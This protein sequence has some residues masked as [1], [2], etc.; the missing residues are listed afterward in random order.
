M[1]NKE[2]SRR[3]FLKAVASAAAASVA[4]SVAG[5]AWASGAKQEGMY[6]E[7][8]MLADLVASGDLPS[9]DQ[10]IPT[11][12]R[13]VTPYEEVGEYGGTWRRAFKGLS[14]RWGPTKLNEE[15]AIEWDAPDPDTTNLVANYISEW[16]QND[17]ATSFTFKLR[18]GLKWS[19]GTAL[20]TEAVQFYYDQIFLT[21]LL[22][23][24]GFFISGGEDM[25][26]QVVDDLTWT[27]TFVQPNPLL[28]IN[29]A[30]STGGMTGGPSMAAPGHYLSKYIGTSPDADQSLIDA[31]LAANGLTTWEEL[32]YEAAPGDGRGPINFWYRNPELPVVNAWMAENS[33]LEDPYMMVRNPYYHAV[34]TEG[35]QLPYVDRI[36]HSLFEDNQTLNL[37]IAQGLIDMQQRHL[38][39]A[40]FTFFKEN[41]E[42]GGYHVINWKA[43]STNAFHPS[44]STL[45]LELR[46]IFEQPEFRQALSIAINRDE[47]NELLY[48]GVMTPR[49]ASPVHGSPEFFEEFSSKWTEYDPDTA[50]A[51]L[52]GLGYTERDADGY[53]LRPDGKTLG[54]TITFTEV[55]G[56]MNPDEVQLVS[57]YWEAIGIKVSQEV[58]ERSLYEER[59]RTGDIEVGVWFVDRS[60]VVM[61]DP[62]RYQGVV[63]DGPWA[64]LYAHY[65]AAQRTADPS[66]YGFPNEKPPEG[67]PVTQIWA[68]WDQVVVEPDDATRNALFRQLLE[69][70]SEHPYMIGTVGEDPQPVIVGNN[71]YNVGA[72]FISDD[73]MRNVGLLKPVQFFMKSM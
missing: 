7:A 73:T 61:A 52:D 26:L 38:A 71:F 59:T 68:L 23:K 12:P 54:F 15:M 9:V 69:I 50:N 17:N 21:Q 44:I 31:A 39:V 1:S 37:W 56:S 20:T 35:Q 46:P 8:P 43:A 18:E 57:G 66:T 42:A 47:L 51:L 67:H 29:I 48:N 16:S 10:R 34:D 53:R 49:Q 14:D 11:N 33:P 32:H 40:D 63:N 30:K 58:V 5:P 45:T 25:G 62:G 6:H 65:E 13:V 70:H 3:D 27:I 19:D 55:L 36:Q 60:S 4:V 24:P 2:L 72:G 64:P 41:E 28:P 22:N